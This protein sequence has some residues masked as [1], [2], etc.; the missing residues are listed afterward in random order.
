MQ[1][2]FICKEKLPHFL[3]KPALCEGTWLGRGRAG[4][5]VERPVHL[6][7]CPLPPKLLGEMGTEMTS[8]ESQVEVTHPMLPGK[9]WQEQGAGALWTGTDLANGT[10]SCP[11]MIP[12]PT[13]TSH[14]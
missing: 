11:S 7:Q 1:T 3:V 4:Y 13:M 9:G 6:A 10:L 2:A 5:P 12:S 14:N 8:R